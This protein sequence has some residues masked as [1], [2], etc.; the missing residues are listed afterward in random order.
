MLLS[1][2]DLMRKKEN[3]REKLAAAAQAAADE[4]I[5]AEEERVRSQVA[6]EKDVADDFEAKQRA[7][8]LKA[9]LDKAAIKYI[10][11]PVN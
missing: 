11:Q 5:R 9:A 3:E 4:K 2:P 10:A 8:H 7:L 6:A 1:K